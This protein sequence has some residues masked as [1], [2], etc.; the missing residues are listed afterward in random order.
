MTDFRASLFLS[1]LF[2]TDRIGRLEQQLS[3]SDA[4]GQ[5]DTSTSPVVSP[6]YEPLSPTQVSP[7]HGF[8]KRRESRISLE[9]ELR[10]TKQSEEV[11]GIFFQGM[12][13]LGDFYIVTWGEGKSAPHKRPPL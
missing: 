11:R 8:P 3:K 6:R 4:D 10:K 2:P 5:S 9:E 7:A 12:L 13:F 1:T